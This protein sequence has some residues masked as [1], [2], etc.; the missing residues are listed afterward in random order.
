MQMTDH[1]L[2]KLSR[3]SPVRLSGLTCALVM[4]A[5]SPGLTAQSGPSPFVQSANNSTDYST[6]IAQG[7]I[8]VL[9]GQNMGPATTVGV[10]TFPLPPVLGGTSLTIT[11]GSTK[12]PCPMIYSSCHQVA[13]I[14]PS[15]TPVGSVE[16][17]VTISATQEPSD[18][19]LP[20]G[21]TSVSSWRLSAV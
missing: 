2:I 8:F 15:N 18:R 12:L 20:A 9:F 7:S 10:S 6:T 19:V 13:A 4:L 5:V 16:I 1:S 14:L 3:F 21:L 17:S 11:S